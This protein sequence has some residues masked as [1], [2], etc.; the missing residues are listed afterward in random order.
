MRHVWQYL[1]QSALDEDPII[2]QGAPGKPWKKSGVKRWMLY[3]S[4]PTFNFR[5]RNDKGKIPRFPW[6]KYFGLPN[7][8]GV[9][10]LALNFTEA[11]KDMDRSD[12]LQVRMIRILRPYIEQLIDKF[13]F[14]VM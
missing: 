10:L 3:N 14:T 5:V 7:K 1:N 12:K 2:F 8:M 6:Y 4:Y 11:A 13:H 9:G